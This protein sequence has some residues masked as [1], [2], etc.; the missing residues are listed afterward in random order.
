M[1]NLT[2]KLMIT[3]AAVAMVTG[4][5]SA[6]SLKAD[7]PFAFRAGG[8]VMAPGTYRVTTSDAKHYVVLANFAAKDS[9]I[10]VPVAQTN[11]PKSGNDPVITFDCG[12]GPCELVRLWTA[13]GYPALKFSHSKSGSTEQASLT[14]IRL[15][16]ANGD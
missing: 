15:V 9:V 3:A 5:A 14:E 7:I 10:A 6:E 1:K 8:K 2:S 11:P 16:R 12:R 13:S 4:V